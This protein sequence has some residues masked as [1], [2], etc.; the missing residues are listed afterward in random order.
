MI[1]GISE[2]LCFQRYY[3]LI[4]INYEKIHSLFMFNANNMCIL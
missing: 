4:I 2:F 1:T 3:S